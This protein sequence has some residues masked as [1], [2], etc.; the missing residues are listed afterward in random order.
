MPHIIIEHSASLDTDF[1]QLLKSIHQSTI[2]TNLFDASTIKTRRVAFPQ[3][4]LGDGKTDFV[5]VQVHLLAGRTQTQKQHLSE[6]LLNTLRTLLS[7]SV[8]LSVHPY[9]LDPAIY[10]K[11]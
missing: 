8:S 4:L 5:H 11:N 10:R 1:S 6:S 3:C 9:D 7:D 2:D